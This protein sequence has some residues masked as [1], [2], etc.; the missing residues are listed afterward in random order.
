MAQFRVQLLSGGL[1]V[2]ANSHLDAWHL[3]LPYR[4]NDQVFKQSVM[5]KTGHNHSRTP[6]IVLYIYFL[7]NLM[8]FLTMANLVIHVDTRPPT[9]T[10]LLIAQPKI[11]PDS[12]QWVTF[13]IVIS[14]IS[15]QFTIKTTKKSH[16]FRSA[17]CCNSPFCWWPCPLAVTCS[18]AALVS[19]HDTFSA[20]T[21]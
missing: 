11:W 20:A 10:A 21:R 6:C 16:F 14:N 2:S 13:N 7:K 15:L 18:D 4:P 1:Q 19:L 3:L 12:A 8:W 5:H 17:V 9:I